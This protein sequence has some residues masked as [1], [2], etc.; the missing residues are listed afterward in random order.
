[1]YVE[2]VYKLQK[3]KSKLVNQ[4]KEKSI[5]EPRKIKEEFSTTSRTAYEKVNQS[6]VHKRN[7][8]EG[9]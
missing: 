8:S 5:V 1:M 2:K 7:E 9:D 6:F 4:E 3:E